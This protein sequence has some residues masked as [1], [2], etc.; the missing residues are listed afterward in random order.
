[1]HLALKRWQF[2]VTILRKCAPFIFSP[3]FPTPSSIDRKRT[4]WEN[5][6]GY[7]PSSISLPLQSFHGACQRGE[8]EECNG[9]IYSNCCYFKKKKRV[10]RK[11]I[12]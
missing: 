5:G 9:A 10:K 11:S 2:L 6:G 1:M 4:E 8:R 7:P 3:H 12:F